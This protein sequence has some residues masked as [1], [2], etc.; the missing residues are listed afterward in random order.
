[1]KIR[2]AF[3]FKLKTNAEIENKL[4][5]FTGS[6]RFVWNKF[7]ALN[8]DRLKSKQKLFWYAEQC[9]W[10]TIWKKSEEY[11]FLREV[12]SQVLQQKLKDLTKAFKD[13]FDK[14]QP[15][16]RMPNFKKKNASDS[17]RYVQGFKLENRRIYLPK[18]GWV[19]FFKS[20]EIL[21][22]IKNITVTRKNNIWCAAI[23]TEREIDI[24]KRTVSANTAIGIDMGV[25]KFATI[26]DGNKISPINSYS[27]YKNKLKKAQK[28]LS[29][30]KKFSNNWKKQNKKA[31]KI[32]TKIANVRRNFLHEASTDLSKNHALIFVE[33]LNVKNM[34]KSAKGTKEKPG[35]NVKQKSGLNRS[36][37]DQSWAEFRR[38]LEY[39]SL[40]SGGTVLAVDPRKTSQKCFKCGYTSKD[41]RKDESF[42]CQSCGY[43]EDADLNAAANILVAGQAMFACGEIPLGSSMKQEPVKNRKKV[44]SY[45]QA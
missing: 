44:S 28:K 9:F 22:E 6:C 36:I 5:K 8:L 1:M 39:K 24:P 14:K 27:K 45:A 11:G 12:H 20:R 37:L 40:W 18:I 7:L 41:N 13:A 26:S 21:G 38:Q 23:Q 43:K 3:L 4:N 34:S 19:G 42:V 29:K 17:F 33:D 2:Q 32:H 25:K 35:K 30:K 16:K 31:N 15:N 10:L